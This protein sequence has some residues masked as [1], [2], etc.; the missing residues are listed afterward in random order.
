MKETIFNQSFVATSVA[1]YGFGSTLHNAVKK[2]RVNH[3]KGRRAE[4]KDFGIYCV[5]FTGDEAPG[6]TIYQDGQLEIEPVSE[7]QEIIKLVIQN[8]TNNKA[9]YRRV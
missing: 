1:G 9:T 3:L 6:L 2:A 7:K 5:L 8:P 4:I